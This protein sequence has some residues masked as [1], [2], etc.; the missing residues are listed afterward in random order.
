MC[1]PPKLTET[2]LPFG[3]GCG[4]YDWLPSLPLGITSL[5]L[6]SG[7]ADFGLPHSMQN[8]PWFTAPQAQD[9]A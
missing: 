5:G 3:A 2:T 1:P 9:Q 6:P 4:G 8:L 7:A